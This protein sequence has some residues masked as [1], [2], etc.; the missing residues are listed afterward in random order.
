MVLNHFHWSYCFFPRGDAEASPLTWGIWFCQIFFFLLR[1]GQPV[2]ERSCV[3]GLGRESAPYQKLLQRPVWERRWCN[4]A[5]FPA[6]GCK[7]VATI[8]DLLQPP[9]LFPWL[10]VT[11]QFGSS[12]NKFLFYAGT[13]IRRHKW[14]RTGL[15][16]EDELQLHWNVAAQTSSIIL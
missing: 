13:C 3:W 8:S 4:H 12:V 6:W 10:C 11:L 16:G 2:G 15:F 5:A 1:S 9:T 14:Q 7:S